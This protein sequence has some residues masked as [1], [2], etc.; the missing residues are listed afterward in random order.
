LAN[1]SNEKRV[2]ERMKTTYVCG[3]PKC[4]PVVDY[5][6]KNDCVDITDDDGD[7]VTM[8]AEQFKRIVEDKYEFL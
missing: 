7:I 5:D 4:C 2:D 8:T 1:E 6:A 3:G